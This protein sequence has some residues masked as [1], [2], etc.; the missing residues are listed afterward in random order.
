MTGADTKFED[1]VVISGIGQSAIGRRLGRSPLALTL[2]AITAAL[3]DAGLS[4]G[5]IGGLTTYPGGGSA[6]GPGFAGPPL[7]DVYDALGLEVDAML[8]NFEGPAQLGPILTGSLAINAGLVRHVV[9]YRTVTEGSARQRASEGREPAA[10]VDWTRQ[11]IT[12]FGGGPGPLGFALLARR[13]FH[14]FG[15]LRLHPVPARRARLA[16]DG[17]RCA[18]PVPGAADAERILPAPG[19]R[20]VLV[21]EG[22]GSRC[23]RSTRTT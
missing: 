8:G 4:P 5:D 10:P 2:D 20:H 18:R 11:W 6:L 22:R 1:R 13:H 21:R 23:C 7:A 12:P 3:E 14:E 19:V 17:H 9:A 16:V 15:R